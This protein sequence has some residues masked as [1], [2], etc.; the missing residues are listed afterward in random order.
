MRSFLFLIALSLSSVG[1]AQHPAHTQDDTG[2]ARP[3]A[4]QFDFLLGEWRLKVTPKVG[5]MAALIH[6]TP[7]LVGTWRAAR[8]FGG[9]GIEDELRISDASGNP[10][11]WARSLRVFS[12]SDNSWRSATV[13]AQRVRAWTGTASWRDGEM[14]QDIRSVDGEGTPDQVR[15]R[16]YEISR[17][18]FRVRQ[19][20]S[21]DDGKSWD[22]GVLDMVATPAS[23]TAQ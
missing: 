23:S 1:Q 15:T 9:Q 13:D 18:G 12:P 10:S 14:W 11:T 21:Y 7:E 17:T 6:G 4:R 3:S 5:G 20:R 19:D 2:A 8:T 22:E 16:F